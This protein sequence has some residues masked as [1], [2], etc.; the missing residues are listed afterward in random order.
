MIILNQ[1]ENMLLPVECLVLEI[2]KAN[3]VEIIAYPV[4]TMCESE[5]S[6]VIIGKYGTEERTKREF[7][8]LSSAITMESKRAYRMPKE[9]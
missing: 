7:M 8:N 3:P 4:E 5:P 6:G 9:K 1:E 2:N